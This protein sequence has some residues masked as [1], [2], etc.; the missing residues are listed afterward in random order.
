MNL[1]SDNYDYNTSTN[2]NN[3]E[4]YELLDYHNAKGD[5][6]QL[7]YSLDS[8]Q[9]EI[10]RT[11]ITLSKKKRCAENE[12][13]KLDEMYDLVASVSAIELINTDNTNL[14]KDDNDDEDGVDSLTGRVK[15]KRLNEDCSLKSDNSWI[16]ELD[17]G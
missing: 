10:S 9:T 2:N 6:K 16:K 12:E 14:F 3:D 8:H 15:I 17:T 11:I 4:K 1:S 13:I 7:G 5:F